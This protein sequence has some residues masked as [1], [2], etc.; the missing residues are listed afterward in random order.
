MFAHGRELQGLGAADTTAF[1]PHVSP[2]CWQSHC[3][4]GSWQNKVPLIQSA[5]QTFLLSQSSPEYPGRHWQWKRPP[6]SVWQV[7]C[8]HGLAPRQGSCCRSQRFP[9]QP[10]SHLQTKSFTRPRQ[11]PPLRHGL[12][13]HR[14]SF[15][16]QRSPEYPGRQRHTAPHWSERQVAPF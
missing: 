14:S 13:T 1:L 6:N 7:P 3:Q 16:S 9:V 2:P 4:L 12:L 10:L 8:R 15:S 5:V 11:V